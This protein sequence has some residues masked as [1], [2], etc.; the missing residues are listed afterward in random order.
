MLE[1]IKC[2]F[3]KYKI[4]F[5]IFEILILGIAGLIVAINS[6]IITNYQTKIAEKELMPI[7]EIIEETKRNN[8]GYVSEHIIEISNIGASLREFTEEFKSILTINYTTYD[9]KEGNTD[10][11][12]DYYYGIYCNNHSTGL[13]RTITGIDNNSKYFEKIRKPLLN[14]N[15][16]DYGLLGSP[17]ASIK[18][19]IKV[20][21]YDLL[22]N[23]HTEY[24][25][26]DT[27]ETK[28]IKE[29]DYREKLQKFDNKDYNEL[30][31]FYIDHD[32]YTKIMK[33][34]SQELNR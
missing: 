2:F 14:N 28:K 10:M 4:F 24:Y 23:K 18:T 25:C 8:E 13:L 17:S 26:V 7:L 16:I 32:D 6:N 19:Y 22:N 9:G 3:E 30:D 21:Y 27:F 34:I 20:E 33:K 11:I 12:I 1:K 5:E 15:Y 31:Y 29:E